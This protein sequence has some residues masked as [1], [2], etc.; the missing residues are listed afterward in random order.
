MVK[1]ELLDYIKTQKKLGVKEPEIRKALIKAGY[2][3]SEI[4]EHF[5]QVKKEVK[6]LKIETKHLVFMNA[7]IIVLIIIAYGYLSYD[8]HSRIAEKDQKLLQTRQELET[9]IANNKIQTENSIGVLKTN[10]QKNISNLRIEMETQDRQINTAITTVET[11]SKS[12]DATLAGGVQALRSES[13]TELEKLT[14]QLTEV[15]GKQVDFTKIIPDVLK[16]VVT[17]GEEDGALFN[18]AGSGVIISV[19]GQIVTNYH[20]IDELKNYRVRTHDQEIHKAVLIG[21]DQTWDIAVLKIADKNYPRLQWADADK[22]Y[23]GQSVMAIGHPEGLEE[24]VTQGII[25]NSYR[26][27]QGIDVPFLQTDVAVNGG[28]SGGPLIDKDGKVV[29]V[30]ARKFTGSGVEGLGFAIRCDDAQKVIAKILI[31][32]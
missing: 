7:A 5:N 18:M 2:E 31:G 14:G 11:E 9:K 22:L 13:S 30:M 15:E 4:E 23:V 16:S 12:R 29:G 25:S 27:I 8:F 6:K 3:P 32:S 21:Y 1:Q 24:T 26:Y 10:L 28:N 17:I 20:V 19:N